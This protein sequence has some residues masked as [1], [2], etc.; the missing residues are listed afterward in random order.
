MQQ[1]ALVACRELAAGPRPCLGVTHAGVLR[2]LLCHFHELPL[3]DL[4][5]FSP[6]HGECV[7]LT[8]TA[9]ELHFEAEGVSCDGCVRMVESRR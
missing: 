7:V 6:A 3:N 5:C 1:R 2:T 9:D 8:G 4:F